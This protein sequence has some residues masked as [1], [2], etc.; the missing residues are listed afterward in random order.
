MDIEKFKV[1]LALTKPNYELEMFNSYCGPV[2]R[3]VSNGDDDYE[4]LV[5]NN[6][7]YIYFAVGNTQEDAANQVIEKWNSRK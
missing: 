5:H 6:G 4:E 1:I 2:A 3:I 7:N